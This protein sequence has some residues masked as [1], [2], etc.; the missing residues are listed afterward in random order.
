MKHTKTRHTNTLKRIALGAALCCSALLASCGGNAGSAP[1]GTSHPAD[2]A[3]TYARALD[4]VKKHIDSSRF[5]IFELRFTE[6][7]E[8]SNDL[9]IISVSMVNADDLFFQQILYMD[10]TPGRLEEYRGMATRETDYESLRGIDPNRIDPEA[11]EARIAQAV[12]MLPEGHTYKS[13]GRYVFEEQLSSRGAEEKPKEFF[14]LRFTE[15]G[16]ETETSGGETVHIYYENEF[17]VGP[18]GT[19]SVEEE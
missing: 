19:L 14:E 3:D 5:K 16:K 8:L 15:D 10:G 12:A 11:M 7:E 1:G 6:G 2:K 18:D 9:S 17:L 4:Q 13:V